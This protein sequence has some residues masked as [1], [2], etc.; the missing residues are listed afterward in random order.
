MGEDKESVEETKGQRPGGELGG[1][2]FWESWEG[3]FS[4]RKEESR[5]GMTGKGFD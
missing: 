2:W 5:T 3:R 1:L 4:R